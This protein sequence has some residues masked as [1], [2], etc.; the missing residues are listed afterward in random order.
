MFYITVKQTSQMGRGVFAEKNFSPGEVIEIC[1]VVPIPSKDASLTSKTILEYW[2]FEWKTDDESAMI[3]GYGM[4]Y[5][6]SSHPNATY[7]SDHVNNS[8]V[9]TASKPI[10]LGEEILINYHQHLP[11]KEIEMLDAKTGQPIKVVI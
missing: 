8:V 10:K 9:F 7:E 1:P 6:H 3:L 4:I 5:N 2:L 11:E